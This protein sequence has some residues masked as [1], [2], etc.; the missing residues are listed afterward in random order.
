MFYMLV[1]HL[2]KRYKPHRLLF[3]NCTVVAL[4]TFRTNCAL[5]VVALF[6]FVLTATGALCLF[7][8]HC[9]TV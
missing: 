1:N 2:N 4:F 5:R 6:T 7:F 9:A 8:M 3:D